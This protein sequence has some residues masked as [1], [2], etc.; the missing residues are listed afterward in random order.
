[1]RVQATTHLGNHTQIPQ[2]ELAHPT[3]TRGKKNVTPVWRELG[4]TGQRATAGKSVDRFQPVSIKHGHMVV[5]RFHN[6]EKTPHIHTLEHCSRC[7]G[8]TARRV[9]DDPRGANIC[10]A[11][12]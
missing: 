3:V 5:T 1:M 6:D 10:L 11:K 2:I 12:A 7:G 9:L 4:V 8:Q